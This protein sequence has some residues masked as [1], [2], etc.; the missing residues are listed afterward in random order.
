MAKSSFTGWSHPSIGYVTEIA[1]ICIAL[2]CIAVSYR[3]ASY[4]IVSY[5]IALY[6]ILIYILCAPRIPY[7]P[8]Y[9]LIKFISFLSSFILNDACIE[10]S[11]D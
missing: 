11:T 3:I 1:F 9:P 10:L 6:C 8:V 4:C 5:R 7:N 2:Y